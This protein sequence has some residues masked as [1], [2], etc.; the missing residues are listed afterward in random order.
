M[1]PTGSKNS[2]VSTSRLNFQKCEF[3]HL[4]DD[5]EE[6]DSQR[7]TAIVHVCFSLQA[8]TH[9]H[10]KLVKSEEPATKTVATSFYFKANVCP[11]HPTHY[12]W[13][14]C[15]QLKCINTHSGKINS[16]IG[17]TVCNLLQNV[18]ELKTVWL[19]KNVTDF[20][21]SFFTAISTFPHCTF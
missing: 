7:K 18:L 16:C 10:S 6:N 9:F 11:F 8:V 17:T 2:T 3:F 19:H 4:L 13:V 12:L 14:V 21:L 20:M 1:I 5:I 15:I